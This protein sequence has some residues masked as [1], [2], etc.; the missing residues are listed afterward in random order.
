[1]ETNTNGIAYNSNFFVPGSQKNLYDNK[2]ALTPEEMSQS[3]TQTISGKYNA[4]VIARNI[5]MNIDSFNRYNPDFDNRLSA[6]GQF[7]LRLPPD[8]MQLFLV[9]KYQILNECV[10]LLLDDS[11]IPN[12]KTVYPPPGKGKAQKKSH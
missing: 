7:D 2:T 4:A 5:N 8:K 10:Q 3:E 12:N 6:N 11:D 1:M 9:N